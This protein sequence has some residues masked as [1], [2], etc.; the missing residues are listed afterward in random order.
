MVDLRGKIGIATDT[1][2]LVWEA[3]VDASEISALTI[4]IVCSAVS[5]GVNALSPAVVGIQHSFDD[6][7]TWITVAGLNG[8]VVSGAGTFLTSVS[9]TSGLIAPLIKVTL[10]APAGQSVTITKARKNRFLPG[11]LISFAG[12]SFLGGTTVNANLVMKYGPAGVFADTAVTY[13]T[14]TPANSRP[15][16]VLGIDSAGL[17]ESTSVMR[18]PAGVFGKYKVAWDTTVPANRIPLPIIR[19]DSSGVP[20][21]LTF[22]SGPG[23][24]Y[25]E[26]RVILDTTTPTST[27]PIPVIQ[28]G[29]S[30]NQMTEGAGVEIQAART[31]EAG[32]RAAKTPVYRDCAVSALNT[33]AWTEILAAAAGAVT[34]LR[35][36]NGTGYPIQISYGNVGAEALEY[37]LPPG[38]EAVRLWIP[39]AT[40]VSVQPYANITGGEL[41]I[42][43]MR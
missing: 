22:W 26:Q 4:A 31:V 18:G 34:E 43:F 10:T 28:V 42:N 35:F 15:L 5:A 2:P 23:G 27:K 30:G 33:G 16:P 9:L 17:E 40:R 14:T 13:D 36:W 32:M 41:V 25:T 12:S 19:I 8:A 7:L 3:S 21:T 1:V 20:D 6:G 37:I 29:S 39:S 38:G 24:A 11:T